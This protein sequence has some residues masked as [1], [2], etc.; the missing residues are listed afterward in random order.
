LVI[1]DVKVDTGSPYTILPKD[2][3][4]GIDMVPFMKEALET[5]S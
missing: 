5:V 1:I 2:V 3:M 4:E